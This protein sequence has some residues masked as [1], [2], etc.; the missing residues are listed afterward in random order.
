MLLTSSKTSDFNKV[1][2]DIQFL[3]QCFREVLTETGDSTLAAALPWGEQPPS[4]TEEIAPL[5]LTQAYSIAFQLLNIVEENAVVQYR[6]YLEKEDAVNRISG[7]WSQ[8]LSLLKQHGLSDQQIAEEL[9]HT[10]VEPVLTAHPTEAKRYTVL[11]QHRELYL[12]M[13][14][15]ENQMWT[16]QEK[17]AIRDSIKA[18]LE[19]LWRTGEIYLN[20]PDVASE[21][22]NVTYYLRHVFPTVLETL[23]QRLVQAWVEAGCDPA[24]L[25]GIAHW[26]QLRFGTWVGGDRDGHPLV[27]AETT[28]RTLLELRTHALA[29]LQ[30]QL[31]VLGQKLSLSRFSHDI[32]EVL[33]EQIAHLAEK[34]GPNGQA[35]LERN[36][37]EPWRQA[38]NLMLMRLPGVE[39]TAGS[40]AQPAELLHDLYQLYDSLLAVDARRLADADVLPVIRIVQTFGFHLAALDIRQNSRF[41]DLAVAQLLAAGGLSDSNFP[42]WDEAK[43]R[44]FLLAELRTPRPFV[45]PDTPLGPEASAVLACYRVVAKR[46][47]SDGNLGLGALIVSMTRDL[48]DLL[49]VYL[50]AR[51]AGLLISTPEGLVCPL[52]VVPLFET[53]DDL[54]RSPDILRAFLAD[55]VTQRSL[56]YHQS[57]TG[58]AEPVQQ[59]MIGYSDSNKDGGIVASLWHLYRAQRTLAQV[60]I[61]EGVRIRFFHGR[62]GSISRGAGPTH[63]FI[64]ALP[65]SALRGD[66]RLTEQGEVIARKYANQQTA[67]HNLELLLS[68]A[69]S[70]SALDRAHAV[71]PNALEPLL[72]RLAASSQEAYRKLLNQEGFLSFYRQAT[73]IDVIESSRIGSRPARRTGQHTLADLRAIPWVF[74]WS[75]S[76]FALS[77]WY[78]LGTALRSLRAEDPAAFDA[79]RQNA[80]EWPIFH[81]IISTAATAVMLSHRDVM[82]A[83]ADLVQDAT[84]RDRLMTLIWEELAHTTGM[85]ETIY[86]GSLFDMRPNVAQVILMRQS[87]LLRLHEQQI[88][89]LRDWRRTGDPA[90]LPSLLITVNAIANGLGA[91]G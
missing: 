82:T 7:L 90:M 70:A 81:N 74:S 18:A 61:E 54:E 49:A 9:A 77:G 30:E 57:H 25:S 32:P 59:V 45:L 51:E 64:R 6:R 73:P 67:V 12:L 39:A 40:Y 38:V 76:R 66:L 20:K 19:R 24:L 91:T 42:D 84:L 17:R 43:R 13:V 1:D 4:L 47:K 15:L 44:A 72:D 75:Q 50:L 11:E 58:A 80:F 85:L 29:L 65:P 69:L 62:G 41:H 68:G 37:E 79:L 33:N 22:R 86:G 35:A 87:P 28:E 56:A 2:D 5:R 63:R 3:I 52:P 10:W 14:Q 8:N 16:P 34:L 26:P 89:L 55:P 83:Y 88:T 46:L 53:I 36:P 31:T 71:Q 27:T 48:S 78:G 21:V 60:G 23:D